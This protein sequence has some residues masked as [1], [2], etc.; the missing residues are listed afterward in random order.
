MDKAKDQPATKRCEACGEVKPLEDF[1]GAGSHFGGD[2]RRRKC[3]VCEDY[4]PVPLEV[5]PIPEGA[6]AL[7]VVPGLGLDC[8][9]EGGVIKLRQVGTD[10]LDEVWLT[11]EELTSVVAF[12]HRQLEV[13]SGG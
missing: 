13:A 4:A 9:F 2:G 1:R 12:V 3:R 10:R 7:Q 11:P 8:W 6:P 5:P